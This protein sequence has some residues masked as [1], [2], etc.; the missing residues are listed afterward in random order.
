LLG[1]KWAGTGQICFA[2][3][4]FAAAQALAAPFVEITSIYR[5]QIMRFTAELSTCALVFGAIFL[6]ARMDMGA[7][8]TIWLMAAAGASGT[9][10]GLAFVWVG[11]KARLAKREAE[12]VDGAAAAHTS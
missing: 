10:A 4:I 5:F 11:F 7:L 8:A 9:L 6:G 3:S 1:A 2:F 12:A